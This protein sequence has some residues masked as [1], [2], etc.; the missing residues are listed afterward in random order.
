MMPSAQHHEI[1]RI[2]HFS[3]CRKIFA[4]RASDPAPFKVRSSANRAPKTDYVQLGFLTHQAGLFCSLRV[5]QLILLMLL[6]ITDYK[7]FSQEKMT[8]NY[9]VYAY[10]PDDTEMR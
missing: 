4:P 5:S 7:S 6:K 2:N 1:G 9:A 10:D 8:Y 3:N